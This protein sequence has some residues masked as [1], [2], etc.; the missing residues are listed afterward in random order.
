MPCCKK[1][2]K[3]CNIDNIIYC[4]DLDG[5]LI[6]GDCTEGSAY[7]MGIPEYL[8]S[9]GLVISVKY[10]TYLD[11]STEY[12]RRVDLE[13][14]GAYAMPYEI[15]DPTTQDPAI[16]DYWASTISNFFVDYT[17]DYL[18]KKASKGNKVWI[19]SASP[20][21]YIA[22]ILNYMDIDRIVAIEP[23]KMISYGPGKMKRV[24]ELTNKQLTG[25]AGYIGDSWNNDGL[26]MT[27]LRNY[28][29]CAS[30]QYIYHNQT[31][32]DVMLNLE[33]YDIKRIDAYNVVV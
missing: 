16:I 13:D 1:N 30:V 3:C 4:S 21:V 6:K 7:Y 23:T 12:F 27:T 22:P 24:Q 11:Y 26:I 17:K 18:E 5:T 20:L 2:K 29:E 19:V 10:P 32:N 31:I 14:T 15:Y 9:I 8:Y 33:R 28:N 25:I